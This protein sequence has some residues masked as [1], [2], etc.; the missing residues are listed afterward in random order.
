MATP[1]LSAFAI[2]HA[3]IFDTFMFRF[4]NHILCKRQKKVVFH[5]S[6]LQVI[7]FPS[8]K[9]EFIANILP[10]KLTFHIFLLFNYFQLHAAYAKLSCESLHIDPHY[11]L[12][13]LLGKSYSALLY[14]ICL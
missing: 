3:A 5:V 13:L 8:T 2:V 4:S 6:L 12:P 10:L 14:V 11:S 7:D 9:C 1:P